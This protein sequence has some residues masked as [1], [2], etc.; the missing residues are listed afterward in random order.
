MRS[1]GRSAHWPVKRVTGRAMKQPPSSLERM[2]R[3]IPAP[4]RISPARRIAAA[5]EK[6][7]RGR[8]KS[9]RQSGVV[10]MRGSLKPH[11]TW[12]CAQTGTEGWV[13]APDN[14]ALMKHVGNA[15]NRT[16]SLLRLPAH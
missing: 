10:S 16:W 13:G 5:H 7:C 14:E 6:H 15:Y 2:S 1:N 9:E 8:H 4:P 11:P 3:A 12:K